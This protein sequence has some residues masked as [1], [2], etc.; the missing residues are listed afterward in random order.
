MR[1]GDDALAAILLE[2][3]I[4]SFGPSWL[5]L[6]AEDQ[7]DPGDPPLDLV[8]LAEVL[9]I[10]ERAGVLAARQAARK[11]DLE[12]RALFGAA[13]EIALVRYIEQNFPRAS[14]EHVSQHDDSCGYDIRVELGAEARN[15]EVKT[16]SSSKPRRIFVSRHEFE[17]ANLDPTWRLVIVELDGEGHTVSVGTV[18][19]SYLCAQAPADVSSLTRWESTQY[20]LPAKV[21]ESGLDLRSNVS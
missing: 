15:L 9:E 7:F 14:V 20:R 1:R 19:T 10:P 13:G 6:L 5:W 12:A 8:Q 16:V 4:I 21:I 18:L 11:V 2:R 17:I 3:L